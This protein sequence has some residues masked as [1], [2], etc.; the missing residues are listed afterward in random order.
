[1]SESAAVAAGRGFLGDCN[2]FYEKGAYIALGA[3]TQNAGQ[4][5]NDPTTCS[6]LPGTNA[7][8]V[9]NI[10]ILGKLTGKNRQLL[11]R[12]RDDARVM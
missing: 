4:A 5:F 1:M 8:P 10:G 6:D 12:L 9:V 3:L 7:C 2:S 11:E